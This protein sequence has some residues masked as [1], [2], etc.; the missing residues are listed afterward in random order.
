VPK[1][2]SS[3]G[4]RSIKTAA[5]M[6]GPGRPDLLEGKDTPG[7][8]AYLCHK[9][10]Q[11][12]DSVRVSQPGETAVSSATARR[13]TSPLRLSQRPALA[14]R[15]EETRRAVGDGADEIDMV[16]DRGAFSRGRYTRSS[17]RSPRRKRRAVKRTSR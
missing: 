2:S 7:K 14:T 17:T 4:K 3:F 10:R 6:S 5:K 11:P 16:I 15:L 12:M 8:V 1:V 9:A 13:C